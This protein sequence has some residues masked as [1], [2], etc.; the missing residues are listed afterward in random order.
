M[1]IISSSSFSQANG[2]ARRFKDM[3]DGTYAE[4]TAMAS[5]NPSAILAGQQ[6]GT[7]AAVSLPANPIVNGIVITA[8]PANTGTIYVGPAGVTAANGYPLVAGQSISYGVTNAS[9]IFIIGA[10]GSVAWTGN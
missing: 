10:V 5:S 3:G 9:A 4:V 2:I 1:D 6:V 7:A 8:L